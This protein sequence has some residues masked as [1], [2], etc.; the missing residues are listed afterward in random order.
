M[1]KNIEVGDKVE[2]SAKC[3]TQSGTVAKL[4]YKT[5]KGRRRALLEQIGAEIDTYVAEILDQNGSSFWTV[6]VDRLK[7]IGKGQPNVAR[8]EVCRIKGKIWERNMNIK[9]K[10]LGA[11]GEHDLFNLRNGDPIVVTYKH[12]VKAERIF[13][14]FVPSS[15]NIRYEQ[16]GHIRTTPP[17][18]VE[19]K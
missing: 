12:G 16:F 3:R 2:F 10:N 7:V 9:S 17:Q 19:R 18:F 8:A 14:G 11:A 1:N 5:C 6:P 15:G 13:R 4:R